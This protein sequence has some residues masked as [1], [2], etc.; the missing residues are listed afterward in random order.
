MSVVRS[1]QLT[2]F[3]PSPSYVTYYSAKPKR[4][5]QGVQISSGSLKLLHCLIIKYLVRWTLTD[6]N[7]DLHAARQVISERSILSYNQI[8]STMDPNRFKCRF[9]RCTASYQRKE[10]LRRHEAQHYRKQV[11]KCTTCD[12]KFSRRWAKK[13]SCELECVF[14]ANLCKNSDTLGRHMQQVHGV[15]QAAHVKLACT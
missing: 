11:F 12:Q 7:A 3:D 5:T 14:L 1:S 9:T 10:H 6:S 15:R 8:S 13:P 4:E 2:Y